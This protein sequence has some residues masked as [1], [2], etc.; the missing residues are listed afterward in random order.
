MAAQPEVATQ[1]SGEQTVAN[2][3]ARAAETN[4]D[5]FTLRI[6]QRAVGQAQDSVIAA[7][8]DATVDH[9]AHPEA[10]LA[11]LGGG[12]MYK[13]HAFHVM[14]RARLIGAPIP[15]LVQGQPH[16]LNDA[17]MHTL[18]DHVDWTGPKTLEYPAK[19]K[20]PAARTNGTIAD[21][22]PLLRISTNRG[23]P[24]PSDLSGNGVSQ[25]AKTL[26][27]STFSDPEVVHLRAQ[28]EAARARVEQQERQLGEERHRLELEAMER[29]R[30][31]D[32]EKLRA[33]IAA[34]SA[35]RDE[36]GGLSTILMELNKANQAA[37]ERFQT[38]M[39]ELNK[40]TQAQLAGLQE[41]NRA[42]MLEL[43]KKPTI[44]PVMEK[45]LVK[46]EEASSA[47]VRVVAQMAE[48]TGSVVNMMVGALHSLKEMEQPSEDDPSWVKVTREI[49]GGIA[50]MEAAKAQAG[51]A[52][53]PTPPYVTVE[54][55][56]GTAS[57][58]QPAPPQH[59][60]EPLTALH[61]LIQA[62]TERR[63]PTSVANFFI[64]NVNDPS[65][66]APLKKANGHIIAAFQPY[67]AQWLQAD[68]RNQAYVRDLLMKLNEVHT[69]RQA[70]AAQP[71]AQ[72]A[73]AAASNAAQ[74]AG[75]EE[76]EEEEEGGDAAGA[77]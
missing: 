43:T 40:A 46:G 74:P 7:F 1:Q 47:T 32:L 23:P 5:E 3:L 69:A 17:Q 19:P 41:T 62:I 26:D 65:I 10:W 14:D 42:L 22:D 38:M 34:N 76:E 72:P 75:E 25:T 2:A 73:A 45:L 64:D 48:A 15:V 16:R 68:A 52:A 33:E 55:L 49:I 4:R 44:D 67:L 58:P 20:A 53:A 60:Q 39:L 70:A 12:G 13:L 57:P 61:V 54:K 18:V 71:A 24:A 77:P 28:L 6:T 50:A 21:V 63:D 51:A 59:A 37:A 66:A 9:L 36:G 56:N 27:G 35:R 8:A 11:Q 31:S 30:Q 29:R